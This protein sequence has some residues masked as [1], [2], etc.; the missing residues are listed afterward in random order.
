MFFT[1]VYLYLL[2]VVRDFLRK[3][4]ICV[5]ISNLMVL[6]IVY[7][8]VCALKSYSGLKTKEYAC[9]FPVGKVRNSGV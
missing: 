5:S 4:E 9:I 7:V 2:S 1:Y 3:G 6:K 8:C